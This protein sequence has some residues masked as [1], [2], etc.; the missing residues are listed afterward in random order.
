MY[1]MRYKHKAKARAMGAM[2]SI[3]A[4]A[5]VHDQHVQM[6][7]DFYLDQVRPTTAR[8]STPRCA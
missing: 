3:T 7:V 1:L 6:D 4:G 8:A 2:S 5:S